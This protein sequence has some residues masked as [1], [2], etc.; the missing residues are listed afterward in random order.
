ML[1]IYAHPNHT[2]HCGTILKEVV[3]ELKK[4]KVTYETLDLYAMNYDPVLHASELYTSGYRD[5][6]KVNREIQ[7]KIKENNRF[8]FIYPTWWNNMPAILK[9]FLD[10]TL[11]PHFA[12]HYVAEIPI[13]L[14][15]GKAAVFTSS[16]GRR[17]AEKIIL[18]NRALNVLTKGTLRFCGIHSKGYIIDRAVELDKKQ[19]EKIKKIVA[20]GLKKLL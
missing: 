12:Y 10:K 20:K 13:G 11:T 1:I 8:I 15:K 18:R 4:E 16:G 9:G 14:L 7:K 5:I 6:S 2:G 17:W 19:K 3:R